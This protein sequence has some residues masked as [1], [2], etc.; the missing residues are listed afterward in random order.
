MSTCI[1]PQSYYQGSWTHSHECL[2]FTYRSLRGLVMKFLYRVYPLLAVLSLPSGRLKYH[3]RCHLVLRKQGKLTRLFIELHLPLL[4]YPFFSSSQ[5]YLT[6]Y[7][8]SWHL[9]NIMRHLGVTPESYDSKVQRVTFPHTTISRC[10]RMRD[11]YYLYNSIQS[12][13]V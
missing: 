1:Q 3:R 11:P 4:L 8:A 12:E 13:L 9:F 5:L 6:S 10:S 2:N 7:R